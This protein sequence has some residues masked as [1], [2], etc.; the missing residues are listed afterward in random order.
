MKLMQKGIDLT[1]YSWDKRNEHDFSCY[2]NIP[3][4]TVAIK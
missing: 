1:F 3:T 4:L 2:I